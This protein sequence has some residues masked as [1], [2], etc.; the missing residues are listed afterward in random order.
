MIKDEAVGGSAGA[1]TC[2]PDYAD[3]RAN[4][5]LEA[6]PVGLRQIQYMYIPS[7]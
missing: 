5:R 3:M 6:Q 1:C 7:T 4:D 2:K